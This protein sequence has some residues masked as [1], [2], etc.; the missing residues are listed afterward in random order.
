MY[1]EL[2]RRLEQEKELDERSKK[3]LRRLLK[4]IGGLGALGAAILGIKT[5]NDH[6]KDL[7]D[8]LDGLEKTAKD[9][10]KDYKSI[11]NERDDIGNICKRFDTDPVDAK[12]SIQKKYG[13]AWLESQMKE[14]K[15]YT[16]REYITVPRSDKGQLGLIR[17]SLKTHYG[18]Y[19]LS[20]DP[21]SDVV[22][23]SP[24][25]EDPPSPVKREVYLFIGTSKKTKAYI[26]EVFSRN[27][28]LKN[29]PIYKDYL[30]VSAKLDKVLSKK[31]KVGSMKPR[32][33]INYALEIR[34]IR[35]MLDVTIEK[36]EDFM[37]LL[38]A[39]RRE[40][41]QKSLE[42][43]RLLTKWGYRSIPTTVEELKKEK[44]VI[45]KQKMSQLKT[46]LGRDLGDA[47]SLLLADRLSSD[48]D[49]IGET[50][51]VEGGHLVSPSIETKYLPRFASDLSQV[52]KHL[53]NK[54]PMVIGE[55][56]AEVDR[57]LIESIRTSLPYQGKS[58]LF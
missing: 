34:E 55:A 56:A 30:K 44:P 52:K 22:I 4:A 11:P 17:Q 47:D 21:K 2:E 14:K 35:D 1:A 28:N 48:I 57:S 26:E 58:V 36:D 12:R 51:R 3:V 15:Y 32:E 8:G 50:K 6:F 40:M 46:L 45:L 27:H 37:G 38:N 53:G 43:E 49:K 19:E 9:T 39:V 16:G 13:R 25:G 5:V 23:L 10:V 41:E 54:L 18:G 33:L 24:K 31:D 42:R 20:Y 7:R 29:T